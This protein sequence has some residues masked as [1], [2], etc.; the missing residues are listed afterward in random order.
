MDMFIRIVIAAG[1]LGWATSARALTRGLRAFAAD[2]AEWVS[3]SSLARVRGLHVDGGEDG[4]LTLAG[5]AS[6]VE[7]ERD[8]R[9][10][11]IQGVQVWL[12]FPT[13]RVRRRWSMRREDAE[14]LV[15]PILAPAPHLVGRGAHVVV[16]DPGHGGEDGGA[17]SAAGAAEKDLLL[18]LARRLRLRLTAMGFRVVLT[19]SDDR[20]MDLDARAAAAARANADLFVSLHLNAAEDPAAGGVET[21]I[22]SRSGGPST[23]G[24]DADRPGPR[25]RYP[26]AAANAYDGAGAI[27]GFHLQRRLVDMTGQPDRGLRQARFAVLKLAPC[28]AA[29]VECAFLSNEADAQRLQVD[30][31][32]EKICAAIAAGIRD[33]ARDV[34]CARLTSP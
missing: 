34:L 7:F 25:A 27:L 18:D 33:Y 1:L 21:Y 31:F 13:A 26:S 24:R 4:R 9:R 6:V 14:R 3:V 22:L 10:A 16:L 30:V 12:Q 15:D 28:P 2:G 23:N 11:S 29:L 20:A 17:V 8:G 5:D 19:R 32:Q